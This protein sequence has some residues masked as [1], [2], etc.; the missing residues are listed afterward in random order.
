M[1][2][3]IIH[4]TSI[5]MTKKEKKFNHNYILITSLNQNLIKL[6]ASITLITTV[7]TQQQYHNNNGNK[8]NHVY[9]DG[10]LYRAVLMKLV[11]RP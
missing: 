1:F 10:L 5:Y 3:D 8:S 2:Y 4:W 11:E 9:S 7:L 6:I